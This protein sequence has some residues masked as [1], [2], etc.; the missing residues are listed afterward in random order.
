[1]RSIP[2]TMADTIIAWLERFE[3]QEAKNKK[4][5]RKN[6]D[7]ICDI[8]DL[9]LA[10]SQ[11]ADRARKQEQWTPALQHGQLALDWVCECSL[12]ND[13]AAGEATAYSE[14]VARLY[15]G[16]LGLACGD[17][18]GAAGQFRLSAEMFGDLDRQRAECIAWAAIG[19]THAGCKKWVDALK[20]YQHSITRIDETAS[21][22]A[23]LKEL[24]RQIVRTFPMILDSYEQDASPGNGP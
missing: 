3:L 9:L 12:R 8:D 21:L 24:R 16:A 15:A 6:E 14:A 7:Q 13:S 20:A 11:R 4:N 2:S 1:M 19:M 10:V 18:H 17:L 5:D 22:D 23:S